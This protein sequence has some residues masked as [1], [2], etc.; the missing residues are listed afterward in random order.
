MK[1]NFF[2]LFFS[3]NTSVGE[4]QINPE[5]LIYSL[6]EPGSRRELILISHPVI[7]PCIH[8]S[9]PESRE[10]FICRSMHDVGI[11]AAAA[12]KFPLYKISNIFFSC[13]CSAFIHSHCC[14]LL[15][16]SKAAPKNWTLWHPFLSSSLNNAETLCNIF[17]CRSLLAERW[18]QLSFF[19]FEQT[20]NVRGSEDHKRGFMLHT[21]N[22]HI[23]SFQNKLHCRWYFA[24]SRWYS[25]RLRRFAIVDWHTRNE[26][27]WFST[28]LSLDPLIRAFSASVALCSD[29]F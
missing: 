29:N 20:Q 21:S 23:A 17:L 2:L 11:S 22:A 16:R 8:D 4:M 19:M 12:L 7:V 26:L 18:A 27:I 28:L 10:H 25:C 15:S 9:L 5:N 6:T 14:L 3:S 13:R 1:F 24:A